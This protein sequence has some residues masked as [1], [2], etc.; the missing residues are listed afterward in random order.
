M[1]TEQINPDIAEQLEWDEAPD[2]EF[3]KIKLGYDNVDFED[4]DRWE[5]YHQWLAECSVVYKRSL[6]EQ[7]Q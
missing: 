7:L 2:A 1:E 6:T 4:S 3:E 5:E